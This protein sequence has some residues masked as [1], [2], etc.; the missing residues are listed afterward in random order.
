M[1]KVV[2]K[3]GQLHAQDLH[4][5]DTERGLLGRQVLRKQAAQPRNAHA[6]LE[7]VVGRAG[8]H[9]VRGAKPVNW[10]TLKYVA[11]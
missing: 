9:V 3:A 1:A 8:E 5:C 11:N 4:R 6:V 7:P 10:S 2:A